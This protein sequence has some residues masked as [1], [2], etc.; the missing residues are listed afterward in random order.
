MESIDRREGQLIAT[1]GKKKRKIA[2]R[3]RRSR[4]K[5]E[6]GQVE[7]AQHK[8]STAQHST[9]PSAVQHSTKQR[10]KREKHPA[11]QRRAELSPGRKVPFWSCSSVVLDG[12]AMDGCTGCTVPLY[13]WHSEPG[14]A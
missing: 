13:R 5:G 8:H 11:T 12:W 6:G 1:G 14:K 10:A 7:C 9:A 3:G 2:R 4:E